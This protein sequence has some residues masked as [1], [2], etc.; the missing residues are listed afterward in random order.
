VREKVQEGGAS[1]ADNEAMTAF[2]RAEHA[3]LVGA[4]TLYT[5]DRQVSEELAQEALVRAFQHWERVSALACPRAWLHKVAFNLAR[6]WFR[7]RQAEHRARARY[8][9]RPV[10]KRDTTDG[11]D[12]L[13]VRAAVRR[14]PDRQ[15]L[16][17]VLRY[18]ADLP[19]HHVA[20]HMG[21]SE[22]TVRAL[23]YQAINAL[24][25]TG[26]LLEELPDAH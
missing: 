9:A 16:A 2:C 10:E 7:R 15:R 22:G 14:L 24:R 6:S 26:G 4:L 19:A 3:R 12:R 21:C 20:A 23:T 18:Y 17:L 5:G 8:D 25:R 13:A 11:A 1:V